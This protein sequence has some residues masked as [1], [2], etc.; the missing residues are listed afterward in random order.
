MSRFGIE[1][2]PLTQMN[3]GSVKNVA[4]ANWEAKSG[5]HC[6][7]AHEGEQKVQRDP[8]FAKIK[9]FA[10]ECARTESGVVTVGDRRENDL[11]KASVEVIS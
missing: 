6:E 7:E 5:A 1:F 3:C 2:R 8:K 4:I 9:I 10:G 11:L